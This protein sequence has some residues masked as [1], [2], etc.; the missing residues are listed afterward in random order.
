VGWGAEQGEYI[1]G[2]GDSIL[3]V[4]EENIYMYQKMA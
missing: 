1:G 4:K 3:N 2:F